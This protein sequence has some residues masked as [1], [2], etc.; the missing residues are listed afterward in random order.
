VKPYPAFA[1]GV[2]GLAYLACPV[3]AWLVAGGGWSTEIW[4]VFAY[5]L[6]RGMA[7]NVFSTYRDIE[8]DAK[9]G[10]YS[11]AVRLGPR[12]AF[13]LGVVLEG[14]GVLLVLGVAISRDE[15]ALGAAVF[16]ASVALLAWASVVTAGSQ[17]QSAD[18]D[19]RALLIFPLRAAR[20]HV[21]IILVQSLSLGL[22]AALITGAAWAME[23]LYTRRIINGGLRKSLLVGGREDEPGSLADN[24]GYQGR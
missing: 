3:T 1:V 24:V 22:I 9:V 11:I 16:M 14:L 13:G 21:A 10:N 2:T 6:C 5:A 12:R 8:G 18:V 4:L 20:N 23:P 7:A 19:D 15:V 17:E